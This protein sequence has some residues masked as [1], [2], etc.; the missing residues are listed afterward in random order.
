MSVL[1]IATRKSPLALWQAEWVKARLE[2][3]GHRCE[4]VSLETLGD[5]KLDVTISKIGSKGVFT[6]ELEAL[7]EMGEV[8]L[9]VHSA[10]DL[11]S[12]L[13][14]GFELI[15]F[16]PREDVHDVLV[17]HKEIDIAEPLLI[18][19]SSTRRVAQLAKYYPHF[20]TTPIRG[21]LQTRMRKMKEGKCDALLLAK[22]GVLRMNSAE[23]I[24]YEF[25]LEQLTTAAGQGSVAVEVHDRLPGEVQEIIRAA[26]NDPDSERMILAERAYLR[27]MNGGCSIPVFSN[28][29]LDGDAIHL[30][31]GI[32]SLDGR[33]ELRETVSGNSPIELGNKLAKIILT[34]G[35]DVI[36]AEIKKH[37]Q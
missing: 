5:K 28:A 10:K 20:K 2:A 15:A 32:L 25:P 1:R 27:G 18:G 22:A 24:Q 4:L 26:T 19:T 7:L 29:Q 30:T 12:E 31:G 11:A 17:S 21:N 6:E 33:T 8:D 13:P 34:A 9:A 14:E 3:A 37:L 36:L 35:G 16:G 23:M